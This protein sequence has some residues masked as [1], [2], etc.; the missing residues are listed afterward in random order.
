MLKNKIFI[1]F[2]AVF[3]ILGFIVLSYSFSEKSAIA[4]NSGIP[5]DDHNANTSE[6]ATKSSGGIEYYATTSTRYVIRHKAIPEDWV[7]PVVDD[8][9]EGSVDA[10]D[11]A[12]SDETNEAAE[13]GKSE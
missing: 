8:G 5:G 9:S 6:G 4:E 10:G 13:S 11:V 1:L 2:T 7:D 12:E 3:L